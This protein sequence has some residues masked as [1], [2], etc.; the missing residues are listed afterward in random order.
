IVVLLIA[1][2]PP[3]RWLKWA[4]VVLPGG[5]IALGLTGIVDAQHLVLTVAA[6]VNIL[7]MLLATIIVCWAA[8]KCHASEAWLLLLPIALMTATG[9]HDLAVLLHQLN[10]PVL[11]SLYYRPLMLIGIAMILM[12]RLGI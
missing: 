7:S 2:R 9:M 12:R 5:C 10:T 8:M 6:P 4:T 1:G 3:P 11:L